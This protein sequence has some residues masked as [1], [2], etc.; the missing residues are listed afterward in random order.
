[1]CNVPQ[2]TW[3]PKLNWNFQVR[4]NAFWEVRAWHT[5][6]II[7]SLPIAKE[8]ASQTSPRQWSNKLCWPWVYHC[9]VWPFLYSVCHKWERGS[10]WG[11]MSAQNTASL[12]LTVWCSLYYLPKIRWRCPQLIFSLQVKNISTHWLWK[13]AQWRTITLPPRCMVAHQFDAYHSSRYKAQS[14]QEYPVPRDLPGHNRFS[15]S[16]HHGGELKRLAIIHIN[17]LK[18]EEAAKKPTCHLHFVR[19][20]TQNKT[21]CWNYCHLHTYQQWCR[22]R[23]RALITWRYLIRVGPFYITIQILNCPQP[24]FF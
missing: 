22:R 23:Q 5:H 9:H 1:M 17:K 19:Q 2:K 15:F 3:A 8:P 4:P 13:C 10:E 21:S 20:A 14:H 18:L 6:L 11:L 7:L 16:L 24:D 12:W